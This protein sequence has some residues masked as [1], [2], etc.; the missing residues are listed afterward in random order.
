[1]DLEVARADRRLHAVP[2]APRLGQRLGDGGLAGAEEP[3]DAPPGSTRRREHHLHR[4]ARDGRGPQSAK[5]AGRPREHDEHAAVRR[6]DEPRS[7]PGDAD[8]VGAVGDRRLLRD[9]G[10]EVGVRPAETLGDRARHRLD[11]RLEPAIDAERCARDACDELDRPVVVRRPQAAGDEADV[12]LAPRP[13]SRLEIDGV[14][15]DDH[16]PLRRE[17]E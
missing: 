7:R 11:L 14:V 1:M 4:I 9:A 15:P 5:L 6:D 2:V 13:E 12:C 3:Q 16:D 10:R 17:P 8:H